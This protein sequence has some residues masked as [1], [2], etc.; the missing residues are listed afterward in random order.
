MSTRI[1]P[2]RSSF[3]LTSIAHASNGFAFAI[4]SLVSLIMPVGMISPGGEA[5]PLQSGH[6]VEWPS[7]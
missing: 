5:P 4:S 2:C 6:T 7:P 1:F 3:S